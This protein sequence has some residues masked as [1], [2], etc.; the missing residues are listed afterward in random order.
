MVTGAADGIGRATARRFAAEGA[1]VLACDVNGEGLDTL[2]DV[3][4]LVLDVTAQGAP[5]TLMAAA[6]DRLGGLDV[7]VNNAGTA[8]GAPIDEL[9]EA[10][11]RRV[12]DLNLDAVL[13][14]SRA[15]IPLLEA[16]GRGR[17]VNIGSVMSERAAPGMTAYTVS[18]HGVA[19]LSRA[20]A[21]ELGPRGITVNFV[22]P[23]AIVT[24]ITRG[25]FDADPAF[26]DFW[27]DKSALGRLG[28]PDDIAGAIAFL[29]SEDASFVTGHGLLVD[30]GALQS[31]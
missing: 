19:G 14:L 23:G 2:A 27:I 31:P 3:E 21:L 12:L 30:G 16:G 15:A 1:R 17:I 4:R 25:V 6:R 11:W 24:G 20:L 10:L 29:A 7:L 22:Q 18:K 28:E 9:T 8:A 26:R 13:W 5:E